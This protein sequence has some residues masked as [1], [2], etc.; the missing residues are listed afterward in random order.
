MAGLP[1]M[2]RDDVGV[3]LTAGAS[4]PAV[5]APPPAQA[6][7]PA[8]AVRRTRWFALRRDIPRPAYLGLAALSFLAAFLFW[9]WV[10]HQPFVNP[11]FVPA[12][13]KVWEAAL[14]FLGDG[15]IWTDVKVSFF[16]VTAGFALSALIA[17]PIGILIGSFK[18]GEGLI[19][20][21]SEFVRY[22]PVPALIPLMMVLFGIG[23]LPKVMLIFAG[24]YFQMVLMVADE[25]RRVPYELVQVSYTLG[26]KRSEIIGKVLWPAALPGVFDA[27]RLCNGWAWTYLVVA[28][29]VAANEGLGYRI[30]KFSR[31]LQTPRIFVYLLLLG[32]IGLTLDMVFRALHRRFFRW[33]ATAR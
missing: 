23:E 2:R 32:I 13:E 6:D 25:V 3:V 31:Y 33:A 4:T 11:V 24:T 28:E 5:A 27:L 9:Q 30:L 29:L 8:R 12:P 16:R 22:I 14:G 18:V 19:Q 1:Q 10:S 15:A 26:A 7:A 20:P 17:I 21:L